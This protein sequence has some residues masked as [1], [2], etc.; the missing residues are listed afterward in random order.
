M[1]IAQNL[2]KSIKFTYGLPRSFRERC[3][4]F[5]PNLAKYCKISHTLLNSLKSVRPWSQSVRD[6]Q[7]A[8]RHPARFAPAQGYRPVA[9]FRA[10]SPYRRN[11][12]GAAS[13]RRARDIPGL[14]VE[15]LS[16]ILPPPPDLL[17]VPRYSWP[18]ILVFRRHFRR[19]QRRSAHPTIAARQIYSG[20]I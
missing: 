7:D 18:A 16:R 20:E 15:A 1:A 5:Y 3:K 4:M 6:L 8:S 13:L 10:A 9:V 11:L 19:F 14:K 17:Q 2:S 12:I